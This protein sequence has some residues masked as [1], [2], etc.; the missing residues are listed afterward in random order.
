[1]GRRPGAA[2]DHNTVL[3]STRAA[4][5]SG[6]VLPIGKPV[7]NVAEAMKG[8]AKVVKPSTSHRCRRTRR[9]SR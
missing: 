5:D 1:V 2:L 3:A 7:G 8:A 6:K 4:A 9:W